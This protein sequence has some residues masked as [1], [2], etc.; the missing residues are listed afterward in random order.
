M[1]VSIHQCPLV[2]CV[3]NSRLD[4][5]S[6]TDLLLL[7]YLCNRSS[8]GTDHPLECS[9]ILQSKLLVF[10]SLL[11]Q[12]SGSCFLRPRCLR[13]LMNWR[14]AS[15]LPRCQLVRGLDLLSSHQT[16]LLLLLLLCILSASLFILVVE[17]L[18]HN[19]HL[20]VADHLRIIYS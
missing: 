6:T 13:I 2:R 10:H 14:A 15:R 12:L 18:I 9:A 20:F 11:L 1:R 7:F 17:C 4:L 3:I 5:T 8:Y 16:L 19:A